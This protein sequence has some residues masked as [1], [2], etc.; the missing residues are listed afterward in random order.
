MTNV[1][2]LS[3]DG[4]HLLSESNLT[5]GELYHIKRNLAI[6]LDLDGPARNPLSAVFQTG[7]LSNE[8]TC[9]N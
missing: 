2:V 7:G 6:A 9:L 3:L 5:T 1:H 4:H 8:R